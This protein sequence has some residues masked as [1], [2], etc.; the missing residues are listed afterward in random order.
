MNTP[1]TT[2]EKVWDLMY[3]N[4][5]LTAKQLCA[6][7]KEKGTKVSEATISDLT[8]SKDK[9][10]SYKLIAGIASHFNVSAD[11]LLGLSEAKTNDKGLQYICDTLHL[12]TKAVEN[13]RTDEP[14]LRGSALQDFHAVGL[15]WSLDDLIPAAGGD[16]GNEVLNAMLEQAEFYELVDTVADSRELY[17][18]AQKQLSELRRAVADDPNGENTKCCAQELRLTINRLKVC[19]YA[20]GYVSFQN[21]LNRVR[22]F[23]DNDIKE[24][25]DKAMTIAFNAGKEGTVDEQS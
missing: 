1:K 12:S 13:M 22:G 24:L 7:L 21:M 5:R 6:E 3:E 15:D 2:G 25:A 4:D 16:I 20:A 10:F 19:Y 8:R 11:Y 9:A 14:R 18:T 17:Q 23:N